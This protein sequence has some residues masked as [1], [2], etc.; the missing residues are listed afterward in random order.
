M[1]L[2]GLL[3]EAHRPEKEG[4]RF[5]FLIDFDRII[6]RKVEMGEK[7]SNNHVL[8]FAYCLKT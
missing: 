6:I 1:S 3:K 2:N 7:T 4:K 5:F 8:I